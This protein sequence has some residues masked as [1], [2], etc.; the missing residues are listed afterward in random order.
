MYENSDYYQ[1]L[2][3]QIYQVSNGF[4]EISNDFSH[5][6][7]QA[8]IAGDYDGYHQFYDASVNADWYSNQLEAA[9]WDAWYGP[10]NSEG[11]T[12]M[13][14]SA[15]YTSMDTS[16]IEPASYASSTSLISDNDTSSYL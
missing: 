2:S 10:V 13:D 1:D 4:F 3:N 16:F 15:G 5:M 8:W 11:Y 9:S 6:A 14:A 12:A 7:D